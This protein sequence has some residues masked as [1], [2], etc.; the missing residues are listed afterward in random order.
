MSHQMGVANTNP[1][2]GCTCAAHE[3]GPSCHCYDKR[4]AS[5]KKEVA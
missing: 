4:P 1:C 3:C 2:A 5:K